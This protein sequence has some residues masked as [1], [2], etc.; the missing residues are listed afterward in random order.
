MTKQIKVLFLAAEAEPFIKIG[1]LGDVSGSL[2]PA[3]HASGNLDIRLVIPFHGAIQRQGF[4]FQRAAEFYVPS[5]DGPIRAEAFYTEL[6][7]L[8]VYLITGT[9]IPPEAPVYSQDYPTD[10]YKFTFFSL[11]AL[12]LLEAIQWTPDILHANDWHTALSIYAIGSGYARKFHKIASLLGVH[13]LPY[14][15]EHVGAALQS[16]ELPPAE[17]TTLPGWAEKMALPLGMLYADHIV[18]VSPSYAKEIMTPEFGSGL[19]GFLR[20]RK[21]SISGILNGI[22]ITV[23][24]PGSDAD[25]AQKFTREQVDVRAINKMVLQ[26]EFRLPVDENIPLFAIVSRLDHQKGIDIVPDA[27][28]QITD[29]RWQAIILGTGNPELEAAI[30]QFEVDFPNQAR[31]AI[32][33]DAKLSQRIYAGADAL[34]IPSRYE[35]CGLTQMIAMR[36]GCIP[37]GRATGGLMD[38]II[39]IDTSRRRGTGFLF[40]QAKSEDL[41]DCL[42]RATNIFAN[43]KLWKRLQQNGMQMDFSWSNSA[44]KYIKLYHSLSAGKA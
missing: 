42:R 10:G 14:L 33:F 12:N 18:T 22:N 35:P 44:G 6:D 15:G 28:R 34:L 32:R 23:W 41:G 26:E 13:N 30:R 7:G 39:D 4:H 8:P 16:F 38:T 9:P 29:M 3:L 2:P 27:F 37:I 11:A 31:A 24:D 5:Q 43:R 20:Q 36:Y 19:D 1:G 25:I 17:N 21:N 40:A